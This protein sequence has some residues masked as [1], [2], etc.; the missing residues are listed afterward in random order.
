[1]TG[2]TVPRALL[3]TFTARSLYRAGA[4]AMRS[5]GAWNQCADRGAPV[6]GL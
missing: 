2:L 5:R 3:D 1:M 4:D 6:S